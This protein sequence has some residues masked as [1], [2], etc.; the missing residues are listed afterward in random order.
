M[1]DTELQDSVSLL[2]FS[3]DSSF[4]GMFNLCFYVLERC[5]LFFDAVGAHIKILP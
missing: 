1:L 5:N 4:L 3:L 2:G